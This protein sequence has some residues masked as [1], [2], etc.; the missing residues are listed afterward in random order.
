MKFTVKEQPSITSG[1]LDKD[2]KVTISDVM[3]AC[4]ILARKSA[5]ILPT[6][7]EIARGDLDKN[8]EITVEDVMEICKLLAR[9]A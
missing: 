1:D 6:E 9:N 8:G 4:K 5:D 2:G 7:D 3:E